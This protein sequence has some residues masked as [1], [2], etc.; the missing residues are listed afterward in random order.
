MGSYLANTT[1]LQIPSTK[2]LITA[3]EQALKRRHTHGLSKH[4]TELQ[5][6]S[7]WN[8]KWGLIAFPLYSMFKTADTNNKMSSV[9]YFHIRSFWKNDSIGFF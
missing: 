7:C 3:R 6:V 8:V 4:D 9:T 5:L 2:H 1:P